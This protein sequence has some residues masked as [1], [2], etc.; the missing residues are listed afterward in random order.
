VH[1]AVIEKPALMDAIL[2]D[3]VIMHPISNVVSYI[4]HEEAKE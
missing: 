1:L 4:L 3:S 2:L